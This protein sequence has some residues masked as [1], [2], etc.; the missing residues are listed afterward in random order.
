MKILEQSI[1]AK[2]PTRKSEDGLVVTNDFIAV[3]DGSTSKTTHRYHPRMNNGR[4]AMLIVSRYIRQMSPDTSCHQFCNG[5]TR[6]IQKRYHPGLL[7]RLFSKTPADPATHPEERLT[8]SAVVYSRLRREI[9][10]I[11]DCQCLINGE[12]CENPKPYE[13]MLAEQRAVKVR[14]MLA[15]G[16]TPE[17]ILANDEAR[18]SI[19]PRMLE[20]MKNQNV[21]YAV[22]DGF[23]IPEHLVPVIT[24]DFRSWEIVLASDGY[25]F[26]CPTLAESEARL[27]HQKTADPLNIGDF[28]ATKGFAAGNNSF[29]DRTYIKFTV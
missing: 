2:S 11:G 8:A 17:E 4:Y 16:R 20:E 29:D 5:V 18:A 26:L 7:R 15:E 25:P 22:I 6:E 1:I 3:I 13:Q 21:T 28:K 23:R 12:L 10:M 27:A 9:W 24:L 14:E 19:I